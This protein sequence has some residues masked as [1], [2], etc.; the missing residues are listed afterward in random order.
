MRRDGQVLFTPDED[1][2][3][4]RFANAQRHHHQL[5]GSVSLE[6]EGSYCLLALMEV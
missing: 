2:N 4:Y 5:L 1:T 6:L 3:G